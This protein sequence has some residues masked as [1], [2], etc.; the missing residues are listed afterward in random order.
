MDLLTNKQREARFKYLG[1]GKYTKANR[2]KFQKMAFTD[3]KLHDSEYG[4]ITDRALR[5]FYNVKRVA[6]NFKPEE[7]KC[8][9]GR[10]SGYPTF[11][12][13]AELKHIQAIRDHYKKPMT[14]TSGLRCSYENE[15][16]GGVANSGHLKGYAVDFYMKGVT[17]TVAN[18]TE[19]MK[20]IVKQPNHEFT[21]GANMRD[22]NGLYRT[23][24]SM[25]NAM[26]TETHKAAK[27]VSPF[28]ASSVILGQASSNEN[29]RLAGGKAGDQKKEVAITGWYNGGWKYM[30]RANDPVVRHKL[31]QAMTDTCL[32]DNIGYDTQKPDRYTA[33]DLAEKNGHNIKGI[34]KKCETT[35]SQ[36]VSMCMRAAGIPEKYAPRHCD[37]A[38]MYKV[39]PKS[40]YFTGYTAAAHTKSP[41]K[42][43]AGDVLLSETH[44]VIITKSPNE[45]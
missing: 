26:H 3:K 25:G 11:M 1:L 35:C 30:F 40:P 39:M 27:T 17:D 21:Y 36:A 32:N 7:F 29:G 24:S 28:Y 13:Q 8:T 9:C 33:W 37:I 23:A 15:R 41:K 38:A 19:A 18:R 22:S 5:H 6:P 34:N 16:V 14:I 43:K 31:A 20:W 10:C 4:V 2:L 12:R 44:T 45:K 42:L